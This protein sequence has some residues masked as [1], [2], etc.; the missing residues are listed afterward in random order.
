MM[1][2]AAHSSIQNHANAETAKVMSL[3]YQVL[4]DQTAIIG[5]LK[6]QDKATGEM[7]ESIV[8]FSKET[9]H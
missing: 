6:Q 2:M 8:N 9:Q 1:K 7:Q 5:V 4:C 3:K